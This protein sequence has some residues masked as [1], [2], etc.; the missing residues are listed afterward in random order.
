MVAG[1]GCD[2]AARP[3]LGRQ[4]KQFVERAAF[5]VSGRELEVLEFQVDAAVCQLGEQLRLHAR[6]PCNPPF[7]APRGLLDLRKVQHPDPDS[8]LR[9]EDRAIAAA[10]VAAAD[11]AT[12][13]NAFFAKDWADFRKLVESTPIKKFKEIE[14]IK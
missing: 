14:T 6:G 13:V 3:L 7:Q 11:V 2:D 12:K 5:L 9:G 4:L 10:T 1:G 8:A